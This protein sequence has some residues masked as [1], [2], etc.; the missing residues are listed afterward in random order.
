MSIHNTKFTPHDTNS[1]MVRQLQRG[2]SVTQTIYTN[3]AN[4]EE[5]RV[6]G[7]MVEIMAGAGTNGSNGPSYVALVTLLTLN[8]L[9]RISMLRF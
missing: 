4:N 7:I 6:Y 1:A 2:T 9:V 5:V 8:Q 3:Q